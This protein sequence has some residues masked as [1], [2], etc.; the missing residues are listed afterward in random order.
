MA[1]L[2]RL[3]FVA[4]QLCRPSALAAAAARPH[5]GGLTATGLVLLPTTD[6]H[7]QTSS[8]LAPRGGSAP[9]ATAPAPAPR[10]VM[11]AECGLN[12]YLQQQRG[13]EGAAAGTTTCVCSPGWHGVACQALRLP[14]LTP[15][16]SGSG[17]YGR[18]PNVTSWGGTLVQD[19]LDKSYHLFVTE[20]QYGC[21]MSSWKSNSAIVHAVS[22]TPGRGGFRRVSTSIVYGTNP[23]VHWDEKAKLWRMLILPTGS[24]ASRTKHHCTHSDAE[25][26]PEDDEFRRR[27]SLGN[28]TNQLYSTPSLAQNWT[29]TSAEFPNCNNPSGAS[30][31]VGT[32]YLLCHGGTKGYGPGFFLYSSADGWSGPGSGW[33][34]HGNILHAGDGVRAGSCEDPSL[35]IDPV[36]GTFHVLAHC[37]S[38]TS[39]NGSTSGEYCSAHLFSD[40]PTN[41]SSWGFHGGSKM[42][43]YDFG[44]LLS[45]RE[46]PTLTLNLR[47]GSPTFLVNGVAALGYDRSVRHRDWAFTLI[48]QVGK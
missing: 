35:Y 9:A 42:A 25:E 4:M 37:Y 36:S 19:P 40:D 15:G 46:R 17:S 2:C 29:V 48:Q 32:A 12:G 44:G 31:K 41:A 26:Q 38:T 27:P 39:W 16:F 28:G 43:P 20:E 5:D 7:S 24:P 1:R 34:A 21:G 11:S 33:Q 30:D 22:S 3:L 45:T 14:N 18:T 10:P 8:S 6:Y 13:A 47:T 23:A